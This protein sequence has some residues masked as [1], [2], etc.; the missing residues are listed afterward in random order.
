ML[1]NPFTSLRAGVI[2]CRENLELMRE[3]PE[4]GIDLI[5]IEPPFFSNQQYEGIKIEQASKESCSEAMA[6]LGI[7]KDLMFCRGN[8]FTHPTKDWG[9]P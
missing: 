1:T 6:E 9:V 3:L 4:E 7:G 2:Y 8:G 5:Y